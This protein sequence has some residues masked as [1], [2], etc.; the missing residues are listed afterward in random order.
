ME[1]QTPDTLPVGLIKLNI[2]V[3]K[4]TLICSVT[5]HVTFIDVQ[6][7]DSYHW[8]RDYTRCTKII[9]CDNYLNG[10]QKYSMVNFSQCHIPCV[11]SKSSICFFNNFL[12]L[13]RGDSVSDDC[14]VLANLSAVS[15]YPRGWVNGD[16]AKTYSHHYSLISNVAQSTLN[17]FCV[18]KIQW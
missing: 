8:S 2:K 9:L 12:A 7:T 18:H 4:F 14:A 13:K 10:F 3:H 1:R 6:G 16:Y 11:I 5:F 17:D 15:L